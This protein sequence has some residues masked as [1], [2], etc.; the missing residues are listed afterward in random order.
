MQVGPGE[1]LARVLLVEP[2]RVTTAR[3]AWTGCDL[4]RRSW[5]HAR[6][7]ALARS[8]LLRLLA[9]L[10][11]EPPLVRTAIRCRS[12]LGPQLLLDLLDLSCDLRSLD[13][14]QQR[15][16]G[17]AVVE[18]E[19]P[20]RFAGRTAA[21]QLGIGNELPQSTSTLSPSNSSPVA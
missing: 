14:I 11:F 19:R 17:D 9:H 13:V 16:V 20:Q 4:A 3:A 18:S 21:N 5:W 15:R 2:G 10:P 12:L 7:L 6:L 1:R 8:L